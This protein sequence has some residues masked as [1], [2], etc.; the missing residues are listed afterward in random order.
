MLLPGDIM[1]IVGGYGAGVKGFH[2]VCESHV[3]GLV[4]FP[5]NC[6]RRRGKDTGSDVS[7]ETRTAAV[8]NDK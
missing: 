1:V 5:S 6:R 8:T 2:F 7:I 3:Q 4:L